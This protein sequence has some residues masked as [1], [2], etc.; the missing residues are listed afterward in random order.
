V[1]GGKEGRGR[2]V[3]IDNVGQGDGRGSGDNDHDCGRRGLVV[4]V[5]EGRGKRGL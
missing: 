5:V 3:V 1:G 2:L 4:A